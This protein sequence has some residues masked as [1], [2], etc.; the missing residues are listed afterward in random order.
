MARELDDLLG[1]RG[2]VVVRPAVTGE[3]ARSDAV[4]RLRSRYGL[5]RPY[6]VIV[7]WGDPRKDL[8]TALAAHRLVRP[9]VPHD[10]V[11]VGHPHA[12]L[13]PVDV[14]D[15]PSV[16]LLGRLDDDELAAV[17]TGAEVLLH[18]SVY[19]GFGLPPLEA[20]AHG[21][22]ALVGDVPA[23]REA[24]WDLAPVLPLR[25]V[26]AWAQALRGALT[27]GL[28]V[29]TPPPWTWTDSGTALQAALTRP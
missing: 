24:T 19:E 4:A 15:D 1:V 16:R 23:V 14:P 12:N 20:W 18:P 13:A 28:P 26:A 5:D 21:T 9:D 17:L 8:A 10:L 6:A 22:P 25:D 7:G 3:P 11:L 29:P 2:A 27:D